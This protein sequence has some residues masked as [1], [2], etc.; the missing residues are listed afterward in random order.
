[1]DN[2]TSTPINK[3]AEINSKKIT[4]PY[5]DTFD[6]LS[7]MDEATKQIL[8]I[9]KTNWPDATAV[10]IWVNNEGIEVNVRNRV[11]INDTSMRKINGE[12]YEKVQI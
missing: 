2:I 1:M 8:S 3:N 6:K 9:V 4:I 12:W 7:P 5:N 10:D 11:I